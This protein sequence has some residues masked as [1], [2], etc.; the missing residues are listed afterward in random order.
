M[1]KLLANT[2]SVF[3][4]TTVFYTAYL[5]YKTYQ[6]QEEKISVRGGDRFIGFDWI[7]WENTTRGIEATFVHPILKSNALLQGISVQEH[8]IL[9]A[10]NY[11]K[12]YTADMANEIIRSAKPGEH[13][14]YQVLRDDPEQFRPF[15]ATII[16][17]CGYYPTFTYPLEKTLWQVQSWTLVF[18]AM[19]ALTLWLILIPIVQQDL[20]TYLLPFSLITFVLLWYVVQNAR[21]FSLILE[22]QFFNV[23]LERWLLTFL[24]IFWNAIAV[25]IFLNTLQYLFHRYLKLC[26]IFLMTI[27]FLAIS[28]IIIKTIFV[29]ATYPYHAQSLSFVTQMIFLISVW[30]YQLQRI[31]H[32]TQ[33]NS[34]KILF[35]TLYFVFSSILLWNTAFS[36]YAVW[37]SEINELLV[38]G[39]L[40]FPAFWAVNPLLRFGKVSLVVTQSILYFIGILLILVLYALIDKLYYFR[41]SY[42]PYNGLVEVLILIVLVLIAQR[43][44]YRYEHVFQR[45]FITTVQKRTFQMKAFLDKIPSYT[46]SEKLLKDFVKE[47]QDYTQSIEVQIWLSQHYA[48]ESLLLSLIDKVKI[49]QM[50]QKSETFWARNKELSRFKLEPAVEEFWI[51]NEVSLVFP[52]E[53][54]NEQEIGFLILKRKKSGVFNLYEVELIRRAITQLQLTLEVLYLLEKEKILIQKNAEANLIALRS[55]INPHFLFNT[56]NTISALIHYKPDLAEQ[57]VEKLAFIFRY[58][59]KYSN[60]NFVT[61][62]NEMSL[63]RSYLEIEQLRFGEQLQVSLNVQH[64]AE[65]VQIPAFCIQTLVEN[66]IK[67]G[68]SNILHVGQIKIDV[69][70]ENS[71]L[72][73]VVYDNGVG[74]DLSRKNKGTGINNVESRLKKLYHREDLLTFERLEQGTR[75]TLRIPLQEMI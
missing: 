35:S 38:Q 55:Q 43:I 52:L 61:V 45:L 26:I 58:T 39:Y 63:V 54:S 18:M 12:V 46:S 2:L 47:I 42:N 10:I 70:I 20:K 19:G 75:A 17:Q 41:F 21:Y 72:Y 49:H 29:D 22:I 32:E 4:L 51:Q 7:K 67:H 9:T 53:I 74:I 56:L 59:L 3:I 23:K 13:L 11:Q 44:Y 65:K 69:F 31:I 15:E 6:T 14:I 48:E 66:C 24:L 27:Y 1:R 60:E 50:M 73:C 37:K 57:A 16:I 36:T 40:V 8:D 5:F 28:F 62:E 64:E 71:F 25:T 30:H 68:L 34:K 33:W